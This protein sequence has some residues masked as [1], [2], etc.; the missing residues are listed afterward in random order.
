MTLPVLLLS[1]YVCVCVCAYT[2]T[3]VTHTHINIH[4]L[5]TYIHIYQANQ[6]DLACLSRVTEDSRLSVKQTKESLPIIVLT[7]Y[8]LS[9]AGRKGEP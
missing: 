2:H 9:S 5:H 7:G 3:I 8:Q 1:V 4:V 6:R